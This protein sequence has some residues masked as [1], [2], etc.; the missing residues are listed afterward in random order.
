MEIRDVTYLVRKT[1]T[2]GSAITEPFNA[3][4]GTKVG[5]CPKIVSLENP[6]EDFKSTSMDF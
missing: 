5:I 6:R 4:A 1:S 3:N 2:V